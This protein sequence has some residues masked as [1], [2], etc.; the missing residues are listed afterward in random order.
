MFSND[1]SELVE[2]TA[3][4]AADAANAEAPVPAGVPSIADAITEISRLR[5]DLEGEGLHATLERRRAE[6]APEDVQPAP[7]DAIAGTAKLELHPA[8][9]ETLN[10]S[11][12][13][14]E[15][16]NTAPPGGG[17]KGDLEVPV[18]KASH[19]SKLVTIEATMEHP[20]ASVWLSKRA[21]EI[22]PKALGAQITETAAAAAED[23]A[24]KTNGYFTDLGLPLGPDDIAA[25]A[26]ENRA[27]GDQAL[28][29]IEHINQQRADLERRLIDGGYFA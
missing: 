11:L 29:D 2:Q 6:V 18:G 20:I 25:V 14:L 7:Q 9:M 12:K 23:L 24:G 13:L 4:A 16:F 3:R 8:V 5:D 22:G 1:L 28:A 15:R 26:D 21:M 10:A 17:G 19:E 27:R